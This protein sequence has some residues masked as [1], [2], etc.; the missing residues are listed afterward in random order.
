MAAL[1][2]LKKG[3][4]WR[5]GDGYSIRVHE[6]RWIPNHRTN[7][8]LYPASQDTNGMLVA[9][10]LDPNLHVPDILLWMYNKNGRFSV[11]SAYRV[12]VQIQKG[13]E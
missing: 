6:D 1:P 9:D 5:V 10:L 2:I 8:V 4:C 13:E 7:K 3:C 12:A 11:K